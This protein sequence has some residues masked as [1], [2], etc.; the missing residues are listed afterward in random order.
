MN[1]R[2]LRLWLLHPRFL[3]YHAFPCHGAEISFQLL[4]IES[5]S[6]GERDSNGKLILDK[7]A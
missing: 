2:Y 1:S 4:V 6:Q 5:H 7:E 3:E